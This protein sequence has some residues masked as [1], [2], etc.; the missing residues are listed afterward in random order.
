MYVKPSTQECVGDQTVRKYFVV[1]CL[2]WVKISS[3][4]HLNDEV[5]N[6][7]RE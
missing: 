6:E 5:V 3:A 7:T 2:I 4:F 1:I